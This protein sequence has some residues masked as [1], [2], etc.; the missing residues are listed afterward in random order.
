MKKLLLPLS[1][2]FAIN[3][4][5]NAQEIADHAI[6]IRIG[7]G[8]GTGG[9]ISYQ[10]SLKNNNRLEVD[11]GFASEVNDFKATGLYQ[12]IWSIEDDF[13]WYAGVGGGIA[14]TD[15]TGV[16]AAGVVGFEYNFQAPI[17]VAIDYRPEIGFASNLGGLVSDIGIAVRYQF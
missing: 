15:K 5:V 1:L 3:L 4:T 2:I 16:Y 17:I 14:S 6:G 8:N 11:L 12:W 13:N 9:E 10:K 7:G